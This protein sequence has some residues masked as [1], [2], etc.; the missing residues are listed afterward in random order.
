MMGATTRSGKKSD[1]VMRRG[2]GLQPPSP[3][4]GTE[5]KTDGTKDRLT[6]LAERD[7]RMKYLTTRKKQTSL[8]HKGNPRVAIVFPKR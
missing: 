5:V 1:Q 6:A 3:E 8:P 7:G 4:G 2:D